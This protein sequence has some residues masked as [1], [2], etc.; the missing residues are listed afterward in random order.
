MRQRGNVRSH[1]SHVSS[2]NAMSAYA[3]T[4]SAKRQ[5]SVRTA[6]PTDNK[7]IILVGMSGTGKSTA[8]QFFRH[9]AD[10][11][12]FKGVDI[13]CRI[14]DE[15]I[16]YAVARKIFWGI[17]ECF[18]MVETDKKLQ[19]ENLVK[20]VHERDADECTL[21]EFTKFLI[22]VLVVQEGDEGAKKRLHV[23][24]A[25]NKIRLIGLASQRSFRGQRESEKIVEKENAKE[26]LAITNQ[27]RDVEK[28]YVGMR[29]KVE[30]TTAESAYEDML[31]KL[32][33]NRRKHFGRH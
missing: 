31:L 23:F 20:L 2:H 9:S 16:P 18:G 5:L 1:H 12:R 19:I 15:S 33:N 17:C 3:V 32:R 25:S 11:R 4:P 24:G 29:D 14:E 28:E 10:R 13:Q 22:D 21:I 8:A 6:G 30:E 26:I 27:E 7:V